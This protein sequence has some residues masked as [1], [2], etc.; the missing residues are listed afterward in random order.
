MERS[1]SSN[2]QSRNT[3]WIGL[4]KS[5]CHFRSNT[6]PRKSQFTNVQASGV[7]RENA[8]L[9]KSTFSIVARRMWTTPEEA[10]RFRAMSV[11]LPAPIGRA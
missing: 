10:S 11:S 5:G 2:L 3:L 4:E 8:D 9:R 7:K 6:S 1:A